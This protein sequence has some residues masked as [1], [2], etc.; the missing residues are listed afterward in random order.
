MVDR[1]DCVMDGLT[2]AQQQ[3]QREDRDWVK[4]YLLVLQK[5][6]A[7]TG[8]VSRTDV[9]RRRASMLLRQAGR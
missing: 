5:T 6:L 2:C 9:K 4:G 8:A 7:G 1:D 3:T